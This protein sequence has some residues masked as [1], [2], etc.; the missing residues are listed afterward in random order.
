MQLLTI[1]GSTFRLSTPIELDATKAALSAAVAAGGA[2]VDI[3]TVD[4]HTVSVLVTPYS[5]IQVE[6]EYTPVRPLE[7]A[8]VPTDLSWIDDL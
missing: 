6:D 5:S 2:F 1:N 7:Y 4:R 3:A 8:E